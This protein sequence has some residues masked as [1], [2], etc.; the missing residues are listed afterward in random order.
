[1]FLCEVANVAVPVGISGRV[2]LFAEGPAVQQGG[3]STGLPG[4]LVLARWPSCPGCRGTLQAAAVCGM[5][6][7]G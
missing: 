3:C 6:K 1:M 5:I 7:P 4:E 2:R